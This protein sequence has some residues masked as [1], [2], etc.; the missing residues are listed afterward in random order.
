MDYLH[1]SLE[2]KERNDLH[3]DG[4]EDIYIEIIN[5]KRKQHCIRGYIYIY[6]YIY[7]YNS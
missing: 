5:E 6:I 1:N 4:A 3:V 2:I 7:I